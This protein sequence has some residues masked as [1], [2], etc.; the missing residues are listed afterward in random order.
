M[1]TPCGFH[2]YYSVVQLGIKDGDA[3]G[4][5]FVVQDHFSYAGFL[6]F[7]MRLRIALSRFVKNCAGIWMAIAL[8][9]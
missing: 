2:C 9:L 6:F 1:P 7:H 5:S 8:N 4:S 3:Y